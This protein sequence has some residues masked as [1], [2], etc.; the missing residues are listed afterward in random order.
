M[1]GIKF[2]LDAAQQIVA[3]VKK[4]RASSTDLTG[5]PNPSMPVGTSFWAAIV[6][7]GDTLSIPNNFDDYGGNVNQT[8]GN[9]VT[10]ELDVGEGNNASYTISGGSIQASSMFIASYQRI[11]G[12][13]T[14]SFTQSGGTVNVSDLLTDGDGYS[15]Y[16]SYTMTAGALTVGSLGVG[17]LSH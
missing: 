3:T 2:T 14:S 5:T 13:T 4:V 12:Q 10:G 6:D 8:G 16:G 7:V 15:D 11:Y 9:L 1:A 17:D